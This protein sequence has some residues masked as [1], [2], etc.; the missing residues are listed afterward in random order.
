MSGGAF[1][2]VARRIILMPVQLFVILAITFALTQVA[3]GDPV[4]IIG[5]TR[6]VDPEQA[7]LIRE[8]FGLNGGYFERF[9]NYIVGLVT[10]G[11][12][13]P[14]YYYRAP[15]RTV[16]DLLVPRIWISMQIS[17]IVMAVVYGLGIPLG[18]YAAVRRGTWKDPAAIGALKLFDSLPSPIFVILTM[19]L[20]VEALAPLF[21]L[22]GF[23]VPEAWDARDPARFIVPV[24]ALSLPVIGGIAR[25]VR[26]SMLTAMDDDYIRTARA[27]GLGER[28]ILYVHVFRNAM[29]P[30]STSF[31]LAIIGIFTGSIVIETVY[32]VPG[33]GQFIFRSITQRDFNVLLGSTLFYSFVLLVAVMI[34]DILYIFIDPRIR[35]TARDV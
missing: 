3:P 8:E 25:F 10:E 17:L 11:D 32:G 20:M 24:F 23:N 27:K 12:L 28:R 34:V 4:S 1:A 7:E 35:Y 21:N 19:A 22:F 5:G 13:G 9:G 15:K 6:A 2:I 14:S 33:V 18:V 31:G 16:E 30:L 26:V 29:L